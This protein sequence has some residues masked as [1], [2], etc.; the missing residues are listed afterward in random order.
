[1]A[2]RCYPIFKQE[3]KY[4]QFFPWMFSKFSTANETL[5]RSLRE[6]VAAY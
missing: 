6:A 1:M 3:K 4:I 2:E 5:A